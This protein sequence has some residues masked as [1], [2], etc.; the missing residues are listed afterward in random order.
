[1][2]QVESPPM[3]AKLRIK[4]S[5]LLFEEEDSPF[6]FPQLHKKMSCVPSNLFYAKSH[7]YGG[8]SRK[9]QVKENGQRANQ[10]CDLFLNELVLSSSDEHE[11][12]VT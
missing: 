3:Q 7:Y 10:R 12:T 2:P 11:N 8:K 6:L 1:M 9:M 5:V 4:L